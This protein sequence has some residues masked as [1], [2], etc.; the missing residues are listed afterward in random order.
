MTQFTDALYGHCPGCRALLKASRDGEK[1]YCD[2]SLTSQEKCPL[3]GD[4]FSDEEIEAMDGMT[5][6]QI[7]EYRQRLIIEAENEAERQ[8]TERFER[9]MNPDNLPSD[10][11]YR[12]DMIDAGRGHLLR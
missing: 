7:E 9:N 5:A 12:A 4:D 10:A 3:A 8:G 11:R 2:S 6:E 1:L